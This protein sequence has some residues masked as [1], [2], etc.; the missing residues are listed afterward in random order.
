M[1]PTLA[2][3]PAAPFFAGS[4]PFIAA[5]LRP[6]SRRL[7][8]TR[9]SSRR[10]AGTRPHAL[11]LLIVAVA[12]AGGCGRKIVAKVNGE[13][14]H[15]DDFVER[16]LN[17]RS[18][19]PN[20]NSA[21]GLQ[22]LSNMVNDAV[23]MQEAR[24]ENV[25]P[26]DAEVNQRM[27]VIAQQLGQRGTN[28]DQYLQRSGMTM[29]AAR[30]QM[31]NELAHRNLITKGLQASDA[32][33]Q[34]FYDEH[35]A[36]FTTPEQIQIHQLTVDSEASAKEARKD[37]KSA[38]FS[39]VALTRSVDVFK[40]AGG[41]VP[42][43]PRTGL[44]GLPVDPMVQQRA[45]TMKEGQISDPI[46]AGTKWVIIK[47]DKITPAKTQSLAEMKDP[48]REV[49]L[50]QKAMQSGQ[51][52]RTEQRLSQIRQEANIEV[53]EDQ[54]KNAPQFQ[55]RP[56]ASP[57]GLPG[58]GGPPGAAPPPGSTAE[59]SAPPPSSPAPAG[60]S[61]PAGTPAPGGAAAGPG[62]K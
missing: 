30:D 1:K 39:L 35:K 3:R 25:L 45:F 60:N 40:Q 22:A 21:A 5:S 38:D 10:L 58:A 11:L 8:G 62:K 47:V 31:R 57:S 44:Q 19:N 43:F 29:E 53:L 27:Q 15:R 46:H 26:T 61:A 50:Q 32:E 17:F 37:L 14:I 23:V 9:P 16:T 4:A 7:A 51:L 56:A 24:R 33:I 18:F 36:E 41:A 55:K 52:Q 48:I 59:P 42:P 20:D 49:V 12:A 2:S 6:T 54:Y 13:P 34:K 28:L